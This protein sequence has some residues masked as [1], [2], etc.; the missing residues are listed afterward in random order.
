[1]GNKYFFKEE[2]AN[3]WFKRNKDVSEQNNLDEPISLLCNLMKES[4]FIFF[5]RK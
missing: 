1:M 3:E 5:L 2:E 4:P